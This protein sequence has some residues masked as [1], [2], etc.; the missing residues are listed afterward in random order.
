[1]VCTRKL[2]VQRRASIVTLRNEG[3]SHAEIGRKLQISKSTVTHTEDASGQNETKKLEGRPQMTTRKE[4]R[5]I[6]II[7]KRNRRKTLSEIRAEVCQAFHKDLS[8][9]TVKR[10]LINSGLNGLIA[11]KKPLLGR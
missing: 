8:T 2:T 7:C 10:R 5:Y 1:M 9:T 11:K 3:Y 4:D 6:I